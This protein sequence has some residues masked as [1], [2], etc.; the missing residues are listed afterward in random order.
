MAMAAGGAQFARSRGRIDKRRDILDAAF[1]VFAREGYVGARIETIA[2][3][4]GVAKPT[5]Y[6]H[7]GDKQTLFL[8]A[9]SAVSVDATARSRAVISGLAEGVGDLRKAFEEVGFS[10]LECYCSDQACSLRRLLHAEIVRFPELFSTVR[11]S[12]PNQVSEALA[13]RMA[14]LQ[15]AG[16]LELTNPVEAAEQFIAL[17][18]GPMETRS[19]LGT[20]RVPESVLHATAN[21]AATTFL[22]AFGVA[23]E[24]SRPDDHPAQLD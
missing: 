9:M 20:Q 13:D 3:E 17:L 10:L 14:R 1:T 11:G 16:R 21:S 18:T 2:A 23:A 7:F 22:K 5:V 8:E 15:V 6:T 24:T 19:I 12:G 4:A